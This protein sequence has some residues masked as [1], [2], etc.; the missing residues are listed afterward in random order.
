MSARFPLYLLLAVLLVSCDKRQDSGDAASSND[1]KRSA[2]H[3]V[4]PP[5]ERTVRSPKEL[6]ES[7]GSA[8]KIESAEERDQALAEI[9]LDAFESEPEIAAAAFK[10]MT[11]DSEARMPLIQQY[12]ML[13]VAQDPQKALTWADSL[14][15]EKEIDAAKE[16]IVHSLHEADLAGA[17]KHLAKAGL[18]NAGP[19]SPIMYVL[20]RWT[21]D[22]PA[23]A[24]AWVVTFPASES[25][26]VV[27]GNVASQWVVADPQAALSW[28][29]ELANP[30]VRNDASHAMAEALAKQPPAERET[31]LESADP[32]VRTEL[33]EQVAQ[34]TH[35]PVVKTEPPPATEPDKANPPPAAEPENPEPSPP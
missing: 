17:A 29:A 30:A 6:R 7:L 19:E 2:T 5:H 34:I 16:L 33:E 31:M 15:S 25:R 26:S 20:E 4:R 14:G 10:Q 28:L 32:A 22:A 27:V 35:E 9:A 12:A 3:G 13:Y 18:A 11:T 21:A 24:A 23:D 8:Q 1:S